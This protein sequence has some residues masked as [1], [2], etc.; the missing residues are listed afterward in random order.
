MPLLADYAITPDVF[1][2]TS[3]STADECAARLESIREAML[4]E[5]LVRD[6]RDGEWRAL[7]SS[8]ER[9]W[10]RRGTELV[11]K[12][13][14]QGRLIRYESA[15][16][17][18]PPDDRHWCAEALATRAAR[19]FAGGVI[20]TKGIK[21]EYADNSL[22][23]R[24]D[25]LTSAEWW[26]AR[27]PSVRLARAL[28]DYKTNLDPILRC[29]NSILFI[30]PH[31]DPEKPGYSNFGSLLAQAGN[32]TPR[33]RIEIHRVCYEGSGPARRF[34]MREDAAY[35]ERRFRDALAGPLRDADLNATVFIWDDFHDRYLISNL[36][37]VSLP[38]GFDTTRAPNVRTTWT[39]LGRD[40]RDDVRREFHPAGQRH[41]LAARFELP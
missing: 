18:P 3:Y 30:D 35:F 19:P 28:E 13:A 9:P 41:A 10:H 20:A 17:D 37:G 39:R 5:G 16:P 40:D 12:L 34:P 36:T 29:S 26:A 23:A 33:P 27:S 7:V 22:V 15:L 4:T 8:H 11:K 6:L 2:V 1:D 38:H 14:T 32:R 31:L 24:I 21:D 25:R